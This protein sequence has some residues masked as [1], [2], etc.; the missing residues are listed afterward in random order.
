MSIT[1]A[2]RAQFCLVPALLYIGAACTESPSGER[3][4]AERGVHV[5]TGTLQVAGSRLFYESSGSGPA[6]VLL[7]A[8]FLDRRMW[9]DQFSALAESHR[10]IRYDVRGIGRSGPADSPYESVA[11]LRALLD[12]LKIERANLVGASLGGRIAIDFAIEYPE[13]VG[14]LVLAG[15]GLSGYAWTID[16]DEPWRV[17]ARE[18]AARGDTVAV[19]LAWMLSDY[20]APAMEQPHVAAKVRM[21]LADNVR[22][23]RSILT[24]G[25]QEVQ[26]PSALGRLAEIN[27]PVLIAV[28]TREVAAIQDIADSLKAKV[29]TARTVLFEGA[30]H[31]PNLEQPVAFNRVV[32]AFLSAA[33]RE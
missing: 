1:S 9:D 24:H 22:F 25:E 31:F 6:V 20:M 8:G 27:A 5:D 4:L 33:P 19:A 30:G 15:P 32:L 14:R 16:R 11:D 7:H 13:R 29:P 3:R 17:A 23:W 21:L 28:G 2:M 26:P 10:V 12:G 18:A